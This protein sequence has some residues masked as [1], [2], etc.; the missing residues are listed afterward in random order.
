VTRR[1]LFDSDPSNAQWTLFLADTLSSVALI[2]FEQE[3]L[4][5]FWFRFEARD[6]I[7]FLHKRYPTERN[8]K[9]LT[10][11]E[12]QLD[13]AR[14]KLREQGVVFSENRDQIYDRIAS[15]EVKYAGIFDSKYAARFAGSCEAAS[16]LPEVAGSQP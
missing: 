7:A 13:E 6:K 12:R 16:S 9:R 8:E 1:A 5:A 3:T 15:E 11:A 14:T 10:D 2:K 4:A